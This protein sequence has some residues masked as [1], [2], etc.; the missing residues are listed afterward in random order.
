MAY[1]ELVG[2]EYKPAGKDEKGS[3]KNDDEERTPKADEKSPA[4]KKAPEDRR[5][6][7]RPDADR[8]ERR[9]GSRGGPPRP[10]RAA[11]RRL[12][13]DDRRGLVA[14]VGEHGEQVGA[15]GP[16]A[17]EEPRGHGLLRRRPEHLGP[18]APWS[19]V[20]QR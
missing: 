6:R 17:P 20:T 19:D 14:G 3:K 18:V 9:T 7:V 12:R 11:R 10:R 1:L 4:D 15:V 8:H 13:P 16:R 2:Y 5:G